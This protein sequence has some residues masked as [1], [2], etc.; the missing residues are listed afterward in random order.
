MTAGV[1]LRYAGGE[2]YALPTANRHVW[3]VAG[4]EVCVD[5]V[6]EHAETGGV[7]GLETLDVPRP[8]RDGARTCDTAISAAN[9]A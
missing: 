8:P 5:M 7:I 1:L 9:L 6:G 4:V 2:V 3:R